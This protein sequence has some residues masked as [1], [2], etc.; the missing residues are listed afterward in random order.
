MT[1]FRTSYYNENWGF[2]LS[3][4]HLERAARTAS[5]RCVIDSSLTDWSRDVCGGLVP[6]EPDD[7]VLLSTYVC[8]PSLCNDNLSGFVL[9]AGLAKHLGG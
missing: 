5:T 9:A 2:C 6:G 8:H 1:P 7:E 3:Q 4:R